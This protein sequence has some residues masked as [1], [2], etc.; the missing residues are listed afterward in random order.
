MTANDPTEQ[1]WEQPTFTTS[2]PVTGPVFLAAAVPGRLAPVAPPSPAEATLRTLLNLVWPV[3]LVLAVV[4][5]HWVPLLVL[6]LVVRTVLKRRLHVL[7][8]QRR[9]PEVAADLR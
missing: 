9:M 8:W 5:G 1:R 7:R 3:A 4:G 2:E 6:A